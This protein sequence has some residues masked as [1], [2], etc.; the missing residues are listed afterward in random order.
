MRRVGRWMVWLLVLWAL[1]VEA[2]QRVEL[3]L[4]E[5]QPRRVPWPVTTGVPFPRGALEAAE[6]CRL[7]DDTGAEC[8]LQTRTAATWD[9]PR[10][11]VRW[12]TIDFIAHPGRKYALEFGADVTPATMETPL[13]IEPLGPERMRVHT[14]AITAD[15]P[16]HGFGPTHLRVGQT[17]VAEE[18]RSSY[19]DHLGRYAQ[20]GPAQDGQG[21][22]AVETSGPVRACLRIDRPYL[23]GDGARQVDC[24][25]RYHFF[26]GLGLVKVVHEIRFTHST[27]DTRWQAMDYGLRLRLDPHTWQAAADGSGEP[28]NQVLRI[29]PTGQ[30]RQVAS[31]QAIYRHYGNPECRG[32]IVR[33]EG[34]RE[35]Q[36]HTAPHVG[37][38]L[39]VKDSRVAV[40]G[41]MRWFWQQFPVEWQG[42]PDR[43]ALRLWSPR[44]GELDFGPAGIRKFFDSA[45][46][47]YLLD[48]QGVRGTLSPISRYFYFAGR[49]ALDRGEAD[50]L[51]IHKHHEFFLHFAPAE[52]AA[53]GEEY[54][55][56][57]ADPPLALAPGAWNAA[58]GVMGPI[59][60]RPNDSPYEHIVDRLFD[61]S[62]Q[63][64]DTFGDYGWWLFGAGPHY[65]YQWDPETGKHYADPR[66]FEYH[67]YQRETQHWWNYLRGGQRKFL[68]WALPAEDHWV[69]IAV[70]HQPTRFFTEYQSGAVMPAVLDWPRGDWAI[71]STIH[72][73]RHHDNAEA[74]LRGQSQFWGTY[75]RTLETTTLAYYLTGDERYQEVLGY[76]TQYF[77]DL[78]G[79]TSE[80]QDLRPW[81]RQQ[82]WFRPTPPGSPPKT[83]AEMI[84]D[85]APFHS[86]SRHQLTLLFNL[87]TLYEHTWDPK[88][89]QALKEYADAFLD[90]EHPLGV[91]RCQ[92]NR[93]PIRAEAPHMAHYWIPALWRYARA[94]N[95]PRMPKILERYFQACLDADP[96]REDIGVYSNAHIG[97]AYALSNDPR[98]L[99]AAAA[100]LE[101]LLPHGEPLARPEDL[102]PRLYNPYAPVKC[103]TG[104]PRLVWALRE[105]QRRGVAIPPPAVTRP[106]RGATAWRKE[107]NQPA[108][109]T[110]W[111]FDREVRLLDPQGKPV[112]E[113]AVT[114]RQ[115][116]SETQ[117]FD[118]NLPGFAVYEH[119]VALP[120]AAPEGWYTLVPR[121]ETAIVELH[122]GQGALCHAAQPVAVHAGRGWYWQVPPGLHALE[123][124]TAVPRGLQIVA[125]DG[126]PLEAAMSAA[127]WTVSLGPHSAGRILR[128]EKSGGGEVWFRFGN[129][130]AEAAWVASRAELASARPPA[131][132]HVGPLSENAAGPFVAGRF[133]QGVLVTPQTVLN[134]PDHLPGD[135]PNF[136]TR[137]GTL[138]FW[139]KILWDPRLRPAGNVS[140]LSNGLLHARVP[141]KLPLAEWAHVALVWRPLKSDPQ[142]V[143]LHIYVNGIDHANY[144]STH[145]EG[146]SQRPF[147]LP[148]D[149]KWL[150][151]FVSRAPPGTAF[152]LDEV[153]LSSQPRYI[154]PEVVFGGQQTV[155]PYRFDLPQRPFHPD[156]T[157][158]LLFHFD[159]DLRSDPAAGQPALEGRITEK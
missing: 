79:K 70:C 48:W 26:A 135:E 40:T 122:G 110:L 133:G 98:H 82:A 128:L 25:T 8:P 2:A 159:G 69:D 150:Q 63:M 108:R 58:S 151:E 78:A 73:L 61:L 68:D 10:G 31:Y 56:L 129:V 140:Y 35:Q 81:H 119:Q 30:T 4:D 60:A 42:G 5:V 46:E 121:L 41:S 87:A 154:D 125:M 137:Q 146:Y 72:Y 59:A 29:E 50:G 62:R 75:H 127:G 71:D 14:G 37:Q 134:L 131:P 22:I 136:D 138:E 80:S 99:R 116:M 96:F 100:E 109:L 147:S 102:G 144:R 141:W 36:L 101:A 145:W 92:D 33:A 49:A 17:M 77:G 142:R 139:I 103:F 95:D 123:V 148:S 55:R 23:R 21:E 106:Q 115:G 32:G 155:N 157:T 9:G 117:P 126:Q 1:P 132:P 97:Y 90:E 44:G 67:T 112:S 16:R 88:V 91:W 15:F 43:L 86:G 38:W 18:A 11:S 19:L 57:V 130:P 6:H 64:Q 28:G 74:W 54:G 47:K 34:D 39:Q 52:E 94:T 20:T 12:L 104:I 152:V 107:A 3:V 149:G 27:R 120:A 124:Q 45:G 114:S 83:W 76:W 13:R 113:L 143:A 111:G 84:R 105:A 93:A 65:S 158:L 153:R 51:G 53:N 85:Y 118:R 24:R 89:G 66:R 7:V 156:D